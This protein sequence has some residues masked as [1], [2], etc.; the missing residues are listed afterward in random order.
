[1]IGINITF[2]GFDELFDEFRRQRK[3]IDKKLEAAFRAQ[4]MKFAREAKK[5]VPVE[6]GGT[7]AAV[8]WA[9]EKTPG[10]YRGVVGTNIKTMM[11]TATGF[12]GLF[13][14][15]GTK[16]IDVGT[17]GSPR[18]DWPAKRATNTRSPEWMPWLRSSWE[19]V[20]DDVHKA[21]ENVLR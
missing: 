11:V 12:A 2:H 10:G 16:R 21:L 5:H 18:T 14:E 20:K 15:M 1:M 4:A 9:V 17:P 19:V 3:E 7:R 8:R 13:I 6:T